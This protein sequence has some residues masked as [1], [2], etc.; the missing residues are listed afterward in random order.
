MTFLLCS[1]R[2]VFPTAI[3]GVC[4]W[5]LSEQSQLTQV[6]AVRLPN[7]HCWPQL[8]IGCLQFP[9]AIIRLIVGMYADAELHDFGRPV[10]WACHAAL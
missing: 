4:D 9:G 5:L 6:R 1:A 7:G 8:W 2:R 3:R 10:L